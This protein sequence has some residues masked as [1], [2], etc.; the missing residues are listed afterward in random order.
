MKP[1]LIMA[2]AWFVQLNLYYFIILYKCKKEGIT[3]G[4]WLD[5]DKE[6]RSKRIARFKKWF[7]PSKS[8]KVRP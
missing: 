2:L 7:L 1:I 5:R 4:E 8:E 3:L 6:L